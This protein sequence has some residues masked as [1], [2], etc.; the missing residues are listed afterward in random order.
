MLERLRGLRAA[1][2][3]AALS[4]SLLGASGA[5]ASIAGGNPSTTTQHPDVRTARPSTPRMFRC[6]STSRCQRNRRACRTPTDAAGRANTITNTLT[7]IGATLVASNDNYVDLAFNSSGGALDLGQFTAVAIEDGAVTS[8]G[9]TTFGLGK[10]STST[11]HNGA[12]WAQLGAGP[13]WPGARV[14]PREFDRVRV[15]SEHRAT[16]RCRRR[17]K[18]LVRR[19]RRNSRPECSHTGQSDDDRG[20]VP[21]L[22]GRHVQRHHDPGAVGRQRSARRRQ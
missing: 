8:G 2:V 12:C 1:T 13:G 7:P 21:N 18:L 19:R 9:R 6:A 3:V 4:L 20:N 14:K 17:Y 16:H 11:T 10:F 15:R 5:R 22:H